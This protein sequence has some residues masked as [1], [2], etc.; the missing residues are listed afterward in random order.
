MSLLT[1]EDL[2]EK[3]NVDQKTIYNWRKEKNLPFIKIGR[4]IYFREE[5]LNKWL[6][7]KEQREIKA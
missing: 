7:T 1:I 6:M 5:A 4:Q 2:I 3:F